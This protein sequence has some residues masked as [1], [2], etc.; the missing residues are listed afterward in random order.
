MKPGQIEEKL[1]KFNGVTYK[2]TATQN[3]MAFV[4]FEG[5]NTIDLGSM[6]FDTKD[7][8]W[9]FE[10]NG[11]TNKLVSFDVASNK[12]NYYTENG[13]TSIDAEAV[14]C[15]A[16]EKSNLSNSEVLLIN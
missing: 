13:I 9:S 1:K 11:E 8:A 3:K 2:V 6:A 12:L 7:Y 5:V 15:I 14:K 4:K 16:S 10:K